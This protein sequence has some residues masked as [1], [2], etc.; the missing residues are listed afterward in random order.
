LSEV[1]ATI[2]PNGSGVVERDEIFKCTFCEPSNSQ[3]WPIQL[4]VSALD[5]KA[6]ANRRRQ[7]AF[8]R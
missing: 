8:I 6:D 7:A 1:E 3:P 4:T 5:G 2:D